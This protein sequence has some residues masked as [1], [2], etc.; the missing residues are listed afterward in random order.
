MS[1]SAPRSNT[2]LDNFDDNKRAHEQATFEASLYGDAGSSDFSDEARKRVEEADAYERR[3]EEIAQRPNYDPAS[4]EG[5]ATR[6]SEFIDQLADLEMQPSPGYEREWN[7]AVADIERERT[8][9]ETAEARLESVMQADK[10]VRQMVMIANNIAEIGSTQVTPENDTR[11]SQ[12]LKDKEDRLEELLLKFSETS[13]MTEDDKQAVMDRIIDMTQTK[14]APAPTQEVAVDGANAEEQDAENNEE[15]VTDGPEAGSDNEA[16]PDDSSVEA[17]EKQP[18][19][20]EMFD[21]VTAR[22]NAEAKKLEQ[23]AAEQRNGTDQA[24]AD[25]E[26]LESTSTDGLE[27]VDDVA[28]DDEDELVST[29]GLESVDAPSAKTAHEGES[30]EE[31]E[32]RNGVEAGGGDD[33]AEHK[34]DSLEDERRSRRGR[35]DRLKYML[36]PAGFADEMRHRRSQ[37][38][39]A[40]SNDSEY[41]DSDERNKRSRM[42][43]VVGGAAVLAAGVG[44]YYMMKYGGDAGPRFS[45]GN[46]NW[47]N[48]MLG[49]AQ[50][51]IRDAAEQA[52]DTAAAET[53]PGGGGSGLNWNDFDPSA[54]NITNGEGWNSTFQQM[55]IPK[56]QWGDVLRDAGPKLANLGE[57][58]YDNSAKEWRIS[59]PGR[60]SNGALRVI[61]AAAD[62][63]GVN[64]GN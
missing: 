22:L 30:L 53:K 51:T 44:G 7:E 23:A 59:E 4:K 63:N 56:E 48:D 27:A 33:D 5:S 12:E 57:A 1:E 35:W 6:R 34:D 40:R 61:N 13:D 52:K 10:H 25:R 8:E 36:T 26:L 21:D 37:R 49:D 64:L 14:A 43:L 19:V 16:A 45:S 41:E 17:E 18:S 50:D 28:D 9:K 46:G 47:F 32:A 15:S 42:T 24:K 55:D 20:D 39:E 62:R 54:R 60:L 3:L 31:Y 58:Y 29:D 11:L 38:A 2:R